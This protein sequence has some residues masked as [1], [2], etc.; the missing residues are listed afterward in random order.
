M[1]SLV[2]TRP[3]YFVGR[4]SKPGSHVTLVAGSVARPVR[5]YTDRV[6]RTYVA[7]VVV[8]VAVLTALWFLSLHFAA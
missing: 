3:D 5:R 4:L 2:Q 7:V 1:T 8:Q 6:T